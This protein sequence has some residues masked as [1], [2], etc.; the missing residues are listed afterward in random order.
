MHTMG[1][2]RVA[3]LLETLC[4]HHHQVLPPLGAGL[5]GLRANGGLK[6]K[7]SRRRA[8]TQQLVTTRLLDCLHDPVGRPS[9]LQGFHP[10]AR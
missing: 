1:D 5:A 6:N 8:Y 3:P 4:H 7:T 2:R 10:R 9:R